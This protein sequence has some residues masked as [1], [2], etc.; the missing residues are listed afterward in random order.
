MIGEQTYVLSRIQHLLKDNLVF[1]TDDNVSESKLSL[2][3]IALTYRLHP[4]E[5]VDGKVGNFHISTNR[6]SF[7]DIKHIYTECLRT[8]VSF[9]DSEPI[10]NPNSSTY[11]KE[12]IHYALA[13]EWMEAAEE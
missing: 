2:I 9:F 8:G 6:L 12:I 3:V 1:P 5:I 4:I 13:I 10:A 11:P 7:E